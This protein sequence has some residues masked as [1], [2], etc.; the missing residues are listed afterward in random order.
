[1]SA[2]ARIYTIVGVIAAAAAADGRGRHGSDRES[3]AR[4]AAGQAA[5]RAPTGRRRR[6]SRGRFKA[7]VGS[8]PELQTL[9]DGHPKSSFVRLN[10]G[11]ALFWRR[12]DAAALAAWKQAK[13]RAAGHAVGRPCRRSAP[14]GLAGR[15]AAVP[16]DL[17]PRRRP[18]HSAGW[19]GACASSTAAVRS[20]PSGSSRPRRRSR[21]TIPTLRSPRPSG[22]TTRI[23]RRP[24]SAA[25]GRSCAVFRMP[26]R[27][28]STSA[29][30]RSGSEPSVRPDVSYGWRSRKTRNRPF[31]TEARTLLKRL[32]NVRTK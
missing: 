32:E 9:A 17:H 30:S 23:A 16:G 2:R 28:A 6:R 31:G 26:R 27:F 25:W 3:S 7:A 12:D 22:S 29:C 20:R 8:V 14:S 19:S 11:L 18:R 15:P 21:P 4:A 5:F 13:R 1:M 10:L 24:P